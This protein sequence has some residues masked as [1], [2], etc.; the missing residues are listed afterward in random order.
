[1]T[2]KTTII[3]LIV[4]LS[5]TAFGQVETVISIDS[6]IIDNLNN[7]KKRKIDTLIIYNANGLCYPCPGDEEERCKEFRWNNA[8]YFL[9]LKNGKTYF[10]LRDDCFDYEILNIDT[11]FFRNFYEIRDSLLKDSL[12]KPKSYTPHTW[13]HTITF[14]DNKDNFILYLNGNYFDYDSNLANIFNKIDYDPAL[15]LNKQTITKSFDDNL[16]NYFINNLAEKLKATRRRKN[17]R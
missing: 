10:T 15:K 6:I 17:F 14:L 1:M 13:H 7:F 9:W 12:L 5:L 16:Y 2:T 4:L 11:L 8:Y 3:F